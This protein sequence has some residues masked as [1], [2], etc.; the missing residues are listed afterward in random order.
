MKMFRLA[1]VLV[2]L[3]WLVSSYAMTPDDLEGADILAQGRCAHFGDTH[4]CVAL[5]KDGV[6]YLL[7]LKRGE[8]PLA[9][10][11][12][13]EIKNTYHPHELELVWSSNII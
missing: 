5:E 12:V 13:K 3:C 11:K 9:I 2:L 10:Y 6:L 1:V 8:V 4:P 7:L